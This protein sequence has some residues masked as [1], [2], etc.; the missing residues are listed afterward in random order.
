MQLVDRNIEFSD[1]VREIIRVA[2][3]TGRYKYEDVGV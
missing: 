2:M 3:A 1:E